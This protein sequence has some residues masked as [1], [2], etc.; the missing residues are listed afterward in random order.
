MG[1]KAGSKL[2][3]G[4]KGFFQPLIGGRSTPK[5]GLWLRAAEIFSLQIV[6]SYFGVY[7]PFSAYWVDVR[8]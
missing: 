8:A 6:V 4:R 1:L 2:I 3:F 7:K 5:S